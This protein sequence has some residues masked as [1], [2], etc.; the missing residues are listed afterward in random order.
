WQ[1]FRRLHRLKTVRRSPRKI[2]KPRRIWLLPRLPTL[3]FF[4]FLSSSDGPGFLFL[5]PEF[6]RL[7]PSFGRVPQTKVSGI[8]EMYSPQAAASSGFAHPKAARTSSGPVP[9]RD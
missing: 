9:S 3:M 8:L 4:P 7:G 1:A 6:R 5:F 2:G